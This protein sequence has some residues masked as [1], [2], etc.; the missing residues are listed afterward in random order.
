MHG[1]ET[2]GKWNRE[3]VIDIDL[4]VQQAYT[5]GRVKPSGEAGRPMNLRSHISVC[6]TRATWKSNAHHSLT[7]PHPPILIMRSLTEVP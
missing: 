2:V 6:N 7:V 4:H 5:L 3:H 1:A